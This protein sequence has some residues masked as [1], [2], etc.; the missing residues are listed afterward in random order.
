L[1]LGGW[2]LSWLYRLATSWYGWQRIVGIPFP[3]F[4][5]ERLGDR[6]GPPPN[7]SF[8]SVGKLANIQRKFFGKTQS[9]GYGSMT[10][11]AVYAAQSDDDALPELAPFMQKGSWLIGHL[12]TS[13]ELLDVVKMSFRQL[14]VTKTGQGGTNVISSGARSYTT[15]R[16]PFIDKDKVVSDDNIVI[17]GA[18]YAPAATTSDAV[19]RLYDILIDPF[20]GFLAEKVEMISTVDRTTFGGKLWNYSKIVIENLVHTTASPRPPP[21]LPE[22]NEDNA[23][24]VPEQSN[25]V[26]LVAGPAAIH[27]Y[28]RKGGIDMSSRLM[29]LKI[30]GD[31]QNRMDITDN[32]MSGNVIQGVIPQVS[33]IVEVTPDMLK[34]MLGEGYLN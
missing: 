32:A 23:M 19:H 9:R 34:V 6:L 5:K 4:H 11:K 28:E 18:E 3:K 1:I 7:V 13:S 8:L 22:Q 31:T 17:G 33:G 26:A 12:P 20:G 2:G 30:T 15:S 27:P 21:V 24:L 25:D 10:T 14:K 29:K 16:K